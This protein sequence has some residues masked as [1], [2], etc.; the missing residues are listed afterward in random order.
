MVV[1][2]ALDSFKGSLTATEAC[3]C[4]AAGFREVG[5]ASALQIVPKADGGEGTADALVAAGGGAWVTV[6][7]VVGPLPDQRLSAEFGWLPS[8]RVA[9]VE[10]ARASGL[11]LLTEDERNQ[12]NSRGRIFDKTE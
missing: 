2:I 4:V 11:P 8:T 1:V 3:E 12:F 7:D 5:V 6:D 9:I 10:M